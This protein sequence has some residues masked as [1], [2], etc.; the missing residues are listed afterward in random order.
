MHKEGSCM[1]LVY[2]EKGHEMPSD[3]IYLVAPT[4]SSQ[5]FNNL[6]AGKLV[7]ATSFC[8]LC[9]LLCTEKLPTIGCRWCT[10][11]GGLEG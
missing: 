9:V 3:N 2:M 6:D 11:L 7:A 4:F 8:F 10:F 5:I 1:V